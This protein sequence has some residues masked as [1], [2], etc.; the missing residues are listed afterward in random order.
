MF[1]RRDRDYLALGRA[2]RRDVV[3]L[4]DGRAA[5]LVARMLPLDTKNQDRIK[6]IREEL[7]PTATFTNTGVTTT[8]S[9]TVE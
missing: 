4:R 3:D 6:Y 1:T 8:I 9:S 2:V 7:K 5:V